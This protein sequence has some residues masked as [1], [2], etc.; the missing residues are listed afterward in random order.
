MREEMLIPVFLNRIYSILQSP[1]LTIAYYLD[2][3]V[4]E[5][6]IQNLQ[7]VE[8]YLFNYAKMHFFMLQS[9]CLTIKVYCIVYTVEYLFNNVK[10]CCICSCCGIFV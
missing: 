3:Q 5:E 6:R 7:S 10:V 4:E 8:E 9:I 1:E 2:C